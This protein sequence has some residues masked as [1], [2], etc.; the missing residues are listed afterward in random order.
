MAL[1]PN[2][3][4]LNLPA[5]STKKTWLVTVSVETVRMAKYRP[6]KSQSGRLELAQDYLAIQ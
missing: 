6:S 5:F 4:N 3:F 2:L 1:G